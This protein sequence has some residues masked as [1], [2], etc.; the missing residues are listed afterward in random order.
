MQILS[1]ES[2]NGNA[3]R[4]RW[5]FSPSRGKPRVGAGRGGGGRGARKLDKAWNHFRLRAPDTRQ[6]DSA[7]RLP[8][9]ALVCFGLFCPSKPEGEGKVCGGNI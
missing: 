3:L 5:P 9:A 4:D 7:E 6:G 8:P 1:S 2:R